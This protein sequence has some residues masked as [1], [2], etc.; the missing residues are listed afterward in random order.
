[1]WPTQGRFN[2]G[3]GNFFEDEDFEEVV[4]R[5]KFNMKWPAYESVAIHFHIKP[6]ENM[7]DL[8]MA[9]AYGFAHAPIT[10]NDVK[11]FK[12]K[13]FALITMYLMEERTEL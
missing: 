1:M 8:M 12:I 2:D 3:C 11:P 9:R 13:G 5:C 6:T 10:N 4:D 7:L